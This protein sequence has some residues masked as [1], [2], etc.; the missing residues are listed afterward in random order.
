MNSLQTE[1]GA[2][3]AFCVH[4]ATGE[5]KLDNGWGMS[6][7]NAEIIRISRVLERSEVQHSS[8]FIGG[9]DVPLL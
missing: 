1:Y 5:Q 9:N 2:V 7:E 3:E 6:E 4:P 8:P